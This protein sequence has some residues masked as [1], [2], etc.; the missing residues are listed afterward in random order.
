M[1]KNKSSIETEHDRWFFH[2]VVSTQKRVASGQVRLIPHD[3][4]WSEIEAYAREL[5]RPQDQ[6]PT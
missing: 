1:T 5:V 2:Q 6:T 3:A 4:F